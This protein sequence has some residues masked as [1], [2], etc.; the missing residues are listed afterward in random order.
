M[1][2]KKIGAAPQAE[3]TGLLQTGV[4]ELDAPGEQPA[5]AAEDGEPGLAVAEQ[6]GILKSGDKTATHLVLAASAFTPDELKGM[7]AKDPDAILVAESGARLGEGGESGETLV[8]AVAK[9]CHE[10][11]RAYC[12]AIGD[13]S[14]LPW[15][16]ADD[17]QRR[18]CI[19]GVEYTE[20]NPGV[21]AREQHDEW[22]RAK[23]ADGWSYGPAKDPAN[24]VHPCLVA[25]DL[26]P[27]EQQIKDHLFRAAARTMLGLAD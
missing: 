9:V 12:A 22:C 11:N 13:A 10:V 18:S 7:L 15:D 2:E 17:H 16:E 25:Y 4:D 27:K 26:L 14:Q 20:A 24:R 8:E 5:A 3:G 1:V 21:T 6:A 23:L 19:L